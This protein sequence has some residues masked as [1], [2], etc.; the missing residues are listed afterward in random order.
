MNYFHR[1]YFSNFNFD[2]TMVKYDYLDPIYLCKEMYSSR[3][4][5]NQNSNTNDSFN[6]S[7]LY[8][9]SICQIISWRR[10]RNR[11]WCIFAL[12]AMPSTAYSKYVHFITW[13]CRKTST[14]KVEVSKAYTC[15]CQAEVIVIVHWLR[16]CAARDSPRM[17]HYIFFFSRIY[18]TE[19]IFEHN[20][21]I[22]FHTCQKMYSA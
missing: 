18:P 11:N 22:S 8:H 9:S 15:T 14:I 20:I 16:K 12:Y 5:P 17:F 19:I 3:R 10:L 21:A 13:E 2:E 4:M 7:R 1:Y 6:V